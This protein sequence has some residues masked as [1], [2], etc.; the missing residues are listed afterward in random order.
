MFRKENNITETLA[1]LFAVREILF[2]N[3]TSF[4][5]VDGIFQTRVNHRRTICHEFLNTLKQTLTMKSPILTKIIKRFL[6]NIL[7]KNCSS[8]NQVQSVQSFALPVQ[9]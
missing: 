3:V 8:V 4:H 5:P 9:Q 6:S 7:F 1:V 2:S